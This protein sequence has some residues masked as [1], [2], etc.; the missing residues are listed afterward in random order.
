[1]KGAAEALR[2]A[3]R[4]AIEKWRH[5]NAVANALLESNLNKYWKDSATYFKQGS[6]FLEAKRNTKEVAFF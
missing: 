6:N 5:A 1:M 4:N 2:D 3:E